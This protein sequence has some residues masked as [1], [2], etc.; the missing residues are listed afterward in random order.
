MEKAVSPRYVKF[1]TLFFLST[2]LLA[3]TCNLSERKQLVGHIFV[4]KKP[5]WS[6]KDI[7]P[8]K[9]PLVIP[10]V[11]TST[12]SL[13]M[14]PVPEK[15]QKFFDMMLPAILVAK[16]NLDLTRK[17]VEVLSKKKKLSIVEK[18]SLR[19]LM[20][21]FKTN[22]I[23]ILI[24]RLHTFPV[25]IVLAQAAIESGWGS[26]RFFLQANNPFGI[27]SFDPKH[28]RVAAAS[29]RDG[30]KIYLRKFDDLEQSIDTYYVMLA[31]GKPFAAFREARMKTS[32]PDTL[33][34]S[35]KMYS[36]RRDSYVQDLAQLMRTNHLK[37]YDSYK[38]ASIYLR[39][40]KRLKLFSGKL[41]KSR[42]L[43]LVKILPNEKKQSPALCQALLISPRNCSTVNAVQ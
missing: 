8:I 19:R 22:N 28:S 26:S 11:Y 1:I 9:D 37:Q 3:S 31:T 35:L 5:I 38:I 21:K 4:I 7:V 24:K 33:I 39:K 16:T 18:Y 6:P 36:E 27:W 20:K 29:T 15:K 23:H 41:R 32:N 17:E 42:L 12:C 34:Q 2:L 30:T 25:S 13:N 40:S 14:L 43:F 10:Y